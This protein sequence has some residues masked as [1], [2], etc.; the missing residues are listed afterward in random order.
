MRGLIALLLFAAAAIYLIRK[1]AGP[2]LPKHL[3][4]PLLWMVFILSRS[5]SQWLS[6]RSDYGG[7]E[8]ELE[9]N[10]LDAS[11]LLALILLGLGILFRRRIRLSELIKEN[12][13]LF[14][15]YGFAV[16]SFIW[17][18]FPFIAFKRWMKW[19]GSLVMVL[20]ILSEV[21]AKAAIN[22]LIKR[23]TYILV[24]LSVVF[25]RYFPYLGRSYGPRGSADYHGVATQKNE[26]GILLMICGMFLAW[27][28]IVAW[29]KK[30][31]PA[32]KRILAVN[33]AFLAV[34]FWQLYQVDSKTATV[35]LIMGVLVVLGLDL[36]IFRKSPKRIGAY[37]ILFVIAIALLQSYVDIRT[38]VIAST[39]RDLTLT[40]RTNLWP[41]VLAIQPNAAIGAGWDNFWLGRRIL[42]LWEKWWWRPRSAHNGYIEIYLYLGWAGIALLV[43]TLYGGFRKSLRA[44]VTDFDWGRLSLAI[45]LIVL[46]Y[47]YTESGFHRTSPIWFFFLLFCGVT[48]TGSREEPEEEPELPAPAIPLR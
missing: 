22:S 3:L 15:F 26:Y 47:N 37:L 25:I 41:D 21:D 16:L 1:K 31:R 40:E 7:M 48:M 8:V 44:L 10:N 39:G 34:I 17:A 18:D 42:P 9:G 23:C 2:K 11:I 43:L 36:P 29:R 35:C 32:L 24:P 6:F 38:A 12:P 20:V 33:S 45:F 30:D 5:F 14:L 4:V 19:F 28:L 46:L 13:A 27:E